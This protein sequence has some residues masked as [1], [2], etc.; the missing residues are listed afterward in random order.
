MNP[1][2]N[3]MAIFN[4]QQPDY[5]GNISDAWK[6]IF[7]PI[8][9]SDAAVPDGLEHKD[10]WGVTCVRHPDAPGKHPVVT[11]E[12]AVVKDITK[13]K[14]QL[15][16]PS[17]K[18]LDWRKAEEAAAAINRDEMF[19]NFMSTQGL[20]ER[21]HFLMG[22]EESF[23]AY[24]EEPD[25]MMEML[26]AIADF[27]IAAIKEAAYHLHP[28]TILFH[29]D[30]GSKRSL[31]LPPD[32]WREMIK[33]LHREIVQTAHDC[34]MIFL[35]HADCFCEPLAQD[36]VELG[37]DIWQGVIPQNDIVAVQEATEGKLA[38]IGGVDCPAID[39]DTT[40]E[41]DIV[42]EVRRCIDTY[43][44][45]GR[46]FP[47]LPATTLFRK[48]NNKIALRELRSYGEQWACE[49]PIS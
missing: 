5:Y 30:W 15:T 14:S 22:M 37:I 19:V 9:A 46:F 42:T 38:M 7:D 21:S 44:P 18:D 10:S 49:H 33:P 11:P 6:T 8:M 41:E 47:G 32:V 23:C 43:C 28:D 45:R 31:F 16:L 17:L 39:L 4:H 2:E 1:R 12:N 20:F 24:L 27:K 35:H 34:G 13:W 25:A 36:M 40:T 29:D 3:M 26:R 48:D